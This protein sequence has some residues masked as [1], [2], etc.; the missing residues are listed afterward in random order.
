MRIFLLLGALLIVYSCNNDLNTIGDNMI[1][2]EG[3]V[4]V[5]SYNIDETSTV[6]LDSFPTSLNLNLSSPY[7][8]NGHQLTL[9]KV[10]DNTTGVT[11]A[12]PYFQIMGTGFR[13]DLI[14]DNDF[15]YDSLILRLPYDYNNLPKIVIAGDSTKTQIYRLYRL[16]EYPIPNDKDP[17]I[18]DNFKLAMEEEPLATLQVRPQKE[19]LRSSPLYF[20]LGNTL[21]K[22]LFDKM[23]GQDKIFEYPSE[24]FR[25]FAGLTIV[26]D[27]NNTVF[28]P[29]LAT[30]L[31]LDCY[32]HSGDRST[33]FSLP[34]VAATQGGGFYAFTN[35]EHT[36]SP[37]LQN[38]TWQKSLPF[39]E[40]ETAIIQGLD[41]YMMK[42]KLP[43]VTS[44]DAYKTILKVEIELK[45]RINNFENIPEP[46]TSVPIQVFLLDK[47]SRLTGAL[48]D[49]SGNA[50]YGYLQ[51]NPNYPEDRKY[52]ID[53]TDYYNSMVSN[54]TG[55]DPELNLLIGL[56]GS[57]QQVGVREIKT[58]LGDV[59][60]SFDRL[61]LDEI[62]VLRIY[63][64]KYK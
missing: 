7:L 47:Y 11:I 17:V 13:E 59:S 22:E 50:I 38:V 5:L 19:Y 40:S 55:L 42:M 15:V 41:G 9:G 39:S 1:P 43:Y 46:N 27:E 44:G 49:A 28:I 60:T 30:G 63:Y 45:P 57:P 51:A 61:I 64:A 14:K 48:S 32:Y 4:E 62:P 53:I 26:P 34:A 29:L 16:T 10:I 56:K 37:L 12:T 35:I 18:Y 36:P 2:P 54:G 31:A 33:Y 20:K 23:K 24:F 21:G 58:M 3:Y 8:Q 6:R 52:K 25:Y